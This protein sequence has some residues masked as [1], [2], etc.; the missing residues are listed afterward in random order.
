M[1]PYDE[2]LTARKLLELP[3]AATMAAIKSNY[4][5]LLARWHPDKCEENKDECEEMT[6]RIISAYQTIMVYC[7]RYEYCFSED[8]VKKHQTHEQWWFERFGSDPLWG[9]GGNPQK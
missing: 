9:A 5:R 7:H 4:R 8:T 6:R 1:N 2:I 3:E